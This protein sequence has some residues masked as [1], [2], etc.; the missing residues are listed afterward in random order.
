M[1]LQSSSRNNW[2]GKLDRVSTYILHHT[3][4]NLN[5]NWAKIEPTFLDNFYF[6]AKVNTTGDVEVK[7]FFLS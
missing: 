7:G 3:Q 2:M 6:H 5:D 1:F 4:K